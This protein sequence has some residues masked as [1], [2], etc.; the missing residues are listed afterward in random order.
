M[1]TEH[2]EVWPNKYTNNSMKALANYWKWIQITLIRNT[3]YISDT[4]DV[5]KKNIST[6]QYMLRNFHK[7]K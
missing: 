1:D 4:N 5:K 2:T 7:L 6:I 3:I